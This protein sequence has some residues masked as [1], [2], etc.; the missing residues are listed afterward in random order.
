MAF[1]F[2]RFVFEACEGASG[3]IFA[4]PHVIRQVAHEPCTGSNLFVCHLGG[5]FWVVVPSRVGW[6]GAGGDI[7]VRPLALANVHEAVP[8][9]S[10]DRLCCLHAGGIS[11]KYTRAHLHQDQ[12]VV[13][14]VKSYGFVMKIVDFDALV[15]SRAVRTRYR[16]ATGLLDEIIG[17]TFVIVI[18]SILHETVCRFRHVHTPG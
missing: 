4:L 11:C 9:A 13:C 14:E 10:R 6:S 15:V 1:G 2:A 18:L 8:G 16:I 7:H 3:S 17:E 12:V 5:T